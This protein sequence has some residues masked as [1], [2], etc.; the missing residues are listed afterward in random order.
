MEMRRND[1]RRSRAE[2]YALSLFWALAGYGRRPAHALCVLALFVGVAR[3]DHLA[4]RR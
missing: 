1:L 4:T 3:I 2:R